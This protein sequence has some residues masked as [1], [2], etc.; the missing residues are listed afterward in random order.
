MKQC[1]VGRRSQCC[2]EH[3]FSITL[4]GCQVA[5]VHAT[6]YSE[7]NNLVMHDRMASLLRRKRVTVYHHCIKSCAYIH[8]LRLAPHLPS[9]WSTTLV[10]AMLWKM[11]RGR[12]Q[13][14]LYTEMMMAPSTNQPPI[15]V[16]CLNESVTA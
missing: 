9:S 1:L 7:A 4:K 12:K 11:P 15:S 5:P 13:V 14:W 2:L 10:K 16:G 3:A 8:V 6:K